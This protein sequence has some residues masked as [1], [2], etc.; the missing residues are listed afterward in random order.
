MLRGISRGRRSK[1]ASKIET[2]F[3]S[4]TTSHTIHPRPGR[5]TVGVTQREGTCHR[6][7]N[8]SCRTS[9][10]LQ[11]LNAISPLHNSKVSLLSQIEFIKSGG[12]EHLTS[13]SPP[14]YYHQ[15]TVR[16]RRS[17]KAT[18]DSIISMQI[19][20]NSFHDSHCRQWVNLSSCH[21]IFIALFLRFLQ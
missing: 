10:K 12:D 2:N 13:N 7:V 16:S 5:L 1:I 18:I 11:S 14:R 8:E 6:R 4:H 3:G 17:S 15:L 19:P 20:P 21:C 9:C